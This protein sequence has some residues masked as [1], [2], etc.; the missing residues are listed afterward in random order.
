M[1]IEKSWLLQSQVQ[2]NTDQPEPSVQ[3]N[4]DVSPE[5]IS[6]RLCRQPIYAAQSTLADQAGNASSGLPCWSPQT[7]TALC[8]A[9][10]SSTWRLILP[11][12]LSKSFW[13]GYVSVPPESH[14]NF[15][16]GSYDS[17]HAGD[18]YSHQLHWS[19]SAWLR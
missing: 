1:Q 9:P 10:L 15:S 18:I 17:Y 2:L 5:S 13:T 6:C 11:R 8:V 4:R 7:P 19:R 14:V 16:F 12:R 3:P